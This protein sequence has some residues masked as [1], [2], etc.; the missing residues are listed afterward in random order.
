VLGFLTSPLSAEHSFTSLVTSPLYETELAYIL[1]L[2][3]DIGYPHIALCSHSCA[4]RKYFPI[5]HPF[6]NFSKS[7]TLN[8]RVLWRWAFRNEVVTCWYEYPINSIKPWTRMLHPSRDLLHLEHSLPV[9]H[10]TT[11]P[12]SLSSTLSLS[13]TSR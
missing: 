4:P 5:V 1:Q 11:T 10:S 2:F 9:P 13:F 7:S 8:F 6:L 3:Y 12:L